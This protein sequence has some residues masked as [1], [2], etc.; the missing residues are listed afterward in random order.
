MLCNANSRAVT[1]APQNSGRSSLQRLHGHSLGRSPYHGQQPMVNNLTCIMEAII[2]H[3][4]GDNAAEYA[5]LRISRTHT[6][7]PLL[8][9]PEV[10]AMEG[11]ASVFH[12]RVGT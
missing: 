10:P 12:R 4:L 2:M 1:T 9:P 8:Q 6:I 7:H 11:S 5:H 3:S